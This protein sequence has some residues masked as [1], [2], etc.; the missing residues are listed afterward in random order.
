M[1]IPCP[2]Q[3]S[4]SPKALPASVFLIAMPTQ[5]AAFKQQ[6]SVPPTYRGEAIFLPG[7]PRSNIMYALR[8]PRPASPRL[9]CQHRQEL[10]LGV[11][12]ERPR[13]WELIL[14]NSPHFPRLAWE[15]RGDEIP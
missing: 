10:G 4:Q 7:A 11:L 3:H 9:C 15:H 8:C 6:Q 1:I 2:L 12:P 14:S 13:H 5:G